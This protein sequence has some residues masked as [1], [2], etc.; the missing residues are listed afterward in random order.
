MHILSFCCPQHVPQSNAIFLASVAQ[1]TL[2]WTSVL[3]A[4][5]DLGE[6]DPTH[7]E[8]LDEE[9]RLCYSLHLA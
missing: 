8:V 3:S 5:R 7:S 4:A 1:M 6:N 9:L 2:R